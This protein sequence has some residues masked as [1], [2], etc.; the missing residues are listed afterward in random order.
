MQHFALYFGPCLKKKHH[1][2]VFPRWSYFFSP[3]LLFWPVFWRTS[4]NHKASRCG[5]IHTLSPWLLRIHPLLFSLPHVC[6]SSV[7]TPPNLECSEPINLVPKSKN[8]KCS[9]GGRTGC[10]G[11]GASRLK[12]TYKK[13]ALSPPY[14]EMCYF[15]ALFQVTSEKKH[16]SNE[17]HT[18]NGENTNVGW[19][20]HDV[21]WK[22]PRWRKSSK[23]GCFQ[24]EFFLLPD[25]Q[26]CF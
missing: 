1:L 16:V 24:T 23:Q 12:N 10:S 20:P 15:A 3:L 2:W 21:I 8:V 4:A 5:I 9:H 7:I 6:Y 14:T 17:A 22:W 26:P 25:Y 18:A 11:N 19:L 13:C